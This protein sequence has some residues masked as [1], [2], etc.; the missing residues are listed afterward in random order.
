MKVI[1]RDDS[2]VEFDRAKIV[3]AIQKANQAVDEPYR[4][5]DEAIDAIAGTVAATKGRQRLLVEDI[6]DDGRRKV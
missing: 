4:I 1:K 5:D 6:Q 2:I 3:A